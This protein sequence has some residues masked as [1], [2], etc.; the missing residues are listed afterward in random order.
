[1]TRALVTADLREARRL[2][3][4]GAR[5]AARVKHAAHRRA[6]RALRD[7]LARGRRD[8]DV[9]DTPPTPRPGSGWDVA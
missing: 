7:W 4:A 3:T 9:Y 6:R 2:V 8:P 1:M 5:I